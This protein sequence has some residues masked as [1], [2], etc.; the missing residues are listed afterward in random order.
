MTKLSS[1]AKGKKKDS[2]GF[3][4]IFCVASPLHLHHSRPV[5]S[6]REKT[7]TGTSAFGGT[8]KTWKDCSRRD[9]PDETREMVVRCGSN[10]PQRAQQV[11]LRISRACPS[12]NHSCLVQSSVL[13]QWM[14]NGPL[15]E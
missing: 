2:N 7:G 9:D 15:L 4:L 8:P 10:H 11:C 1:H 13:A 6:R 12:H 3:P 5:G 14:E